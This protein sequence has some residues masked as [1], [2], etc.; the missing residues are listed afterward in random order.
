MS[1]MLRDWL[2]QRAVEKVD[3]H[4]AEFWAQVDKDGPVVRHVGT[5]CWLWVGKTLC[6]GYGQ[7]SIAGKQLYTH[8]IAWLLER[9]ELPAHLILCHDCDTPACVRPDHLFVGTTLDNAR[10][11]EAKGRGRSRG[12][13]NPMAK[14][15]AWH[16]LQAK[17]LR[18]EGLSFKE[19]SKRLN[20]NKTT[21]YYMATGEQWKDVACDS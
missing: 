3:S 8:R 12:A 7:F 10:D 13:S 19:I 9:G 14:Y 20:M 17:K 2:V 16:A 4:I 18:A 6:R 21:A 15:T 5:P 1:G 11:R